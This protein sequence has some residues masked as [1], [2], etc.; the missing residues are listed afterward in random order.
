MKVTY[1]GIATYQCLE[2][3]HI[4][5]TDNSTQSLTCTASGEWSPT[6]LQPCLQISCKPPGKINHGEAPPLI[7]QSP[8]L[9]L[10]IFAS[11]IFAFSFFTKFCEIILLRFLQ[12]VYR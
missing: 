1:G 4:T 2:G 5:D 7:F 9:K 11:I 6:P 12:L 10:E 8:T 3:Y